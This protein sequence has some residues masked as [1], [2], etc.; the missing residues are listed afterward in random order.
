L[1]V[2]DNCEHRA[3]AGAG[4]G[5][6][7]ATCPRLALLA[8]SREALRLRAEQVFPVPPLPVPEDDRLA[9]PSELAA[10]PSVALFV[11]R[12]QAGD[13]AF[14]LTEENARAVGA[15]CRRLDGLPLA[16]ELAA[17]RVRH[18]PP[19]V[20]LARLKR[21]LPVLT[22]GARDAPERQQTLRNA[23]AWSYD[24]L[25]PDE[26]DVLRALA[27]F[28]GGCT[29]AAAEAVAA[30]VSDADVFG[31][32]GSLIDK[33]LLLLDASGSEPRYRMLLT[34]REFG[35]EQLAARPDEEAVRRAQLAYLDRLIRETDLF[36]L[37]AGLTTAFEAPVAR[38][39]EE[40]ANVRDAL[41]WA[42][43]R[44]PETAL[45]VAARLGPYWQAQYRPA[46]GLDL[47]VRALAT[48]AGEN[49]PDRALA[50]CEAAYLAIS[51]AEF[52]RAEA[53][54]DAAFALAERLT[55]PLLAAL[56]RYCHGRIAFGRS[57][58]EKAVAQLQDA[59]ARFE[60]LSN[61]AFA[62]GCLNDLGRNYLEQGDE[63][64]AISF[65]ERCLMFDEQR[66][67]AYGRALDLAHLAAAHL[68]L[69]HHEQSQGLATEAL[70]LAEQVGGAYMQGAS[71]LA[72]SLLGDLA[73]DRLE[74]PLAAARFQESLGIRW[75]M[76]D[77]L[78]VAAELESAAMLMA[79]ADHP[80]VAAALYGAADA[81]GEAISS[82][83][84]DVEQAEHERDLLPLRE[85]LGESSFA[86]EWERGRRRPLAE[87]V[88][89][90]LAELGA[91]AECR[92]AATAPADAVTLSS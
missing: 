1:G 12:A 85:A 48:G 80:E 40:E 6:L 53:L 9:S 20:L 65:F 21:A 56:A 30:V 68:Y 39:S 25:T 57:Q 5:D 32:L 4:L 27:V 49:T 42:L 70:A 64:A 16:I 17:A 67:N 34:I 79:A 76:G 72:R 54:A 47:I 71:A 31:G 92:S 11:E 46:P 82:P 51:L 75:E 38:L 26:Q 10:I 73:L 77:T 78:S 83:R 66:Q 14:V 45:A 63:V 23:I 89:A 33:S 2:L 58:G 91:I 90:A 19:P 3:G 61:V 44:D 60:T 52:A 37:A 87:A 86:R 69:G 24:L 22:G 55:E 74:I 15:I 50:L 84:T 28:V 35:Q 8:T 43:T 59:L 29:F 18:F 81:L 62:T 13:P 36:D 88:G 7:L 41:E